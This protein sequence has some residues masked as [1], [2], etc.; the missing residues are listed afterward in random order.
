[1]KLD[2]YAACRPD[3][4]DDEK[5]VVT[6]KGAT[7]QTFTYTCDQIG[8][9]TSFLDISL[10][11]QATSTGVVELEWM[12][13]SPKES[14]DRTVF[15]DNPS[16]VLPSAG[17][18]FSSGA[19][20]S[21]TERCQDLGLTCLAGH[22]DNAAAA[23]EQSN[24]HCRGVSTENSDLNIKWGNSSKYA[25]D[26]CNDK[27]ANKVGC[28][29][30]GD[31]APA[32]PYNT[33]A[34]STFEQHRFTFVAPSANVDIKIMNTAPAGNIRTVLIDHPQVYW[35]ATPGPVAE[36]NLEFGSKSNEKVA[37]TKLI[38]SPVGG[39]D[40]CGPVML[41]RC[42]SWDSVNQECDRYHTVATFDQS[43]EY[44]LNQRV[45][46][47]AR[48]WRISPLTTLPVKFSGYKCSTGTSVGVGVESA[49]DCQAK[50]DDDNACNFFSW[51]PEGETGTMALADRCV[52]STECD[53]KSPAAYV[54]YKKTMGD[55]RAIDF[56]QTGTNKFVRIETPETF[57]GQK[58]FT[59]SFWVKL[60]DK[61]AKHSVIS[62]QRSD[63]TG[64][65]FNIKQQKIGFGGMGSPV[66]DWGS[67]STKLEVGV[68]YHVAG[69][70][71]SGT[72]DLYVNGALKASQS[73]SFMQ[74]AST[75]GNQP[76]V[77]GR[78][79]DE[80]SDGWTSSKH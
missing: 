78:E 32:R 58:D 34:D 12:N 16:I 51:N 59:V 8:S 14:G 22:S 76:I 6:I 43:T 79:W 20:R 69:Y 60:T 53:T 64:W 38:V 50:C 27:Q 55:I 35:S 21:C 70:L 11:F 30:C 52:T 67:G 7:T 49:R 40:T 42:G 73:F 46:K 33:N 57:T 71:G 3:Y 80:T 47:D 15:L 31:P 9:S 36:A 2:F 13:D 4:G 56:P 41:E 48:R 65:N 68:W 10:P 25:L 75:D 28:C 44:T 18:V 5:M 39:K 74:R 26:K 29:R 19:N 24:V 54:T 1:M 45:A 66:Q 61:N 72:A 17:S 77:I 23:G 62:K 37:V 63:G